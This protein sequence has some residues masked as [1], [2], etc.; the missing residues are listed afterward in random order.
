MQQ[1]IQDWLA[2]GDQFNFENM[3]SRYYEIFNKKHGRIEIRRFWV[4]S[5]RLAF[6]QIRHHEGW[7]GLQ[8]IVLCPA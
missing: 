4:V 5:D 8:S 2:Y 3:E 6:E 1:V 7:A